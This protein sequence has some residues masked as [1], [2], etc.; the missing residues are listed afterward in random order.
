MKTFISL[1]LAATFATISFADLSVT[2]HDPL[3]DL[4]VK[5]SFLT[6]QETYGGGSITCG[7]DSSHYCYDP[8]LGEVGSTS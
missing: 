6:C 3:P 4:K 5:R 8:T 7:S 2:Y 1:G